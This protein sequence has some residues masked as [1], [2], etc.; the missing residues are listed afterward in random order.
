[1]RNKLGRRRHLYYCIVENIQ[2]DVLNEVDRILTVVFNQQKIIFKL[3][4]LVITSL[5][6][7]EEVSS[8][9]P[10]LTVKNYFMVCA[11]W[12]FLCYLLS[13]FCTVLTKFKHLS[14]LALIWALFK[15]FLGISR[16]SFSKH[17][18]FAQSISCSN[19]SVC[20]AIALLIVL[21]NIWQDHFKNFRNYKISLKC[22]KRL[23]MD[24]LPNN[25]HS[26]TCLVLWLLITNLEKSR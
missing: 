13:M 18:V 14:P 5:S 3:L 2:C 9:I 26:L 1:M 23:I 12:M 16:F 4:G 25:K 19:C 6:T 15:I 7:G 20:L 24:I 10:D 21:P 22:F 11:D 17:S 8:S